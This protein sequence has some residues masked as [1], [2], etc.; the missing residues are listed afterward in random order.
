MHC[1]DGNRHR[2]NLPNLASAQHVM[3]TQS[4]LLPCMDICQCAAARTHEHTLTHAHT[5][6]CSCARMH[7]HLEGARS[8]CCTHA[9]RHW[10]LCLGHGGWQVLGDPASTK[11]QHCHCSLRGTEYICKY[12]C[13][14]LNT[15]MLR[16][17][18]QR[19]PQGSC[20][21]F[22]SELHSSTNMM[23]WPLSHSA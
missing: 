3:Q 12:T 23:V 21:V 15:N 11:G 9:R 22:D 14:V 13:K 19:S 16:M 5:S 20:H 6:M 7:T 4:R 1:C 8:A 10:S 18:C 2:Y 17:A